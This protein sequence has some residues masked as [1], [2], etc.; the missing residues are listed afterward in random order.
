[1]QGGGQLGML[2]VVLVAEATAVQAVWLV[3][4]HQ[5]AASHSVLCCH[6]RPPSLCGLL[7]APPEY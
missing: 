1:M 7:P 6:P 4:Q 2:H 3:L 5:A